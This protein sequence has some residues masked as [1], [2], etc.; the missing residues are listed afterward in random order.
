[1]LRASGPVS[2]NGYSATVLFYADGT[3]KADFSEFSNGI[4]SWFYTGSNYFVFGANENLHLRFS[5]AGSTLSMSL[6]RVAVANGVVTET[7]ILV[8]G[9]SNTITATDST[10]TSGLAGFN[11]WSSGGTSTM[12][13]DDVTVTGASSN[14]ASTGTYVSPLI[15]PTPI[16]QWKTLSLTQS[17]ASPVTSL[18]VD[19]L[20]ENNNLLASNLLQGA[21][22]GAIPAVA[23]T[24]AIRLRANLSTTSTNSTPRLDDWAVSW[25]AAPDI[26]VL[27]QWSSTTFS[28]QDS[29]APAVG[30]S[31]PRV[32]S[33]PAVSISGTASDLLAVTSVTANGASTATS[34]GF[35]HWQSPLMNLNPG[36]NSFSIAAIDMAT[37]PNV[38]LVSHDVYRIT[39]GSDADRDG[40]PDSWENTHGLD[41]FSGDGKSGA[42]GDWDGDGICN[43]L[44]LAFGMDPKTPDSQNGPRLSVELDPADGLNYLTLSYRRLIQPG[45]VS[46]QIEIS[47]DCAAWSADAART[48]QVGTPAVAGDGLTETVTTRIKPAIQSAGHPRTYVRVRVTAD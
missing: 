13:V 46:Y 45:G 10:Y 26:E 15:A 33:D 30:V 28:L 25:Q 38:S 7:P 32:T 44:E 11:H 42:H 16:H 40:L 20:D 43:L 4:S 27:G 29:E 8:N 31:T 37:P 19:V 3:A 22:L 41:L 21:D 2:T 17:V 6:W 23:A 24:S 39:D 18:T 5:I 12:L 14:Y 48:E 47:E 1:M 36:W 9:T 35:L 34:D